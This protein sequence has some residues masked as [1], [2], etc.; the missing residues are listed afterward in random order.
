MSTDENPAT[1]AITAIIIIDDDDDKEDN[2]KN[3]NDSSSNGQPPSNALAFLSE[4]SFKSIQK[5]V[6]RCGR[7]I[8]PNENVTFPTTFDLPTFLRLFPPTKI[9]V[10]GCSWIQ[11]HN[12]NRK[13][14]VTDDDH[15][16]TND[17]DTDSDNADTDNDDDDDNTSVDL[18]ESRYFRYSWFV[19]RN[20][21]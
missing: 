1:A 11:V 16:K 7:I 6:M 18:L 19:C 5:D 9:V 17:D 14:R 4:E 20:I 10:P 3:D 15:G 12:P 13:R 8:F 21:R 2:D